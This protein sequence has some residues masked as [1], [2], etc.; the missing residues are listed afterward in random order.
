[1]N[2]TTMIGGMAILGGLYFY[3]DGRKVFHT[4]NANRATLIR[5]VRY[6]GRKGRRA[7]K[8]L[9]ARHVHTP[10]RCSDRLAARLA[11]AVEA[12]N[13]I[14]IKAEAYESSAYDAAQVARKALA[15]ISATGGKETR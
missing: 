6:G 14:T 4:S 15:A 9:G 5:R 13:D 8:R 11:M 3:F 12:L 7:A 10:E 1:M 2:W